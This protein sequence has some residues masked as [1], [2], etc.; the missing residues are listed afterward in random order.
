MLG[1]PKSGF[2]TDPGQCLILKRGLK[3]SRVQ[4]K[5]KKKIETAQ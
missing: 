3:T 2:Y 1:N 5:K 4:I